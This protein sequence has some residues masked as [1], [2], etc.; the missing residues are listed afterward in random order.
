MQI[1]KNITHKLSQITLI[2]YHVYLTPEFWKR[3]DVF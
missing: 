1:K 2:H 3:W